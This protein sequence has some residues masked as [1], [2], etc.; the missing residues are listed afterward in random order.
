MMGLI[1]SLEWVVKPQIWKIKLGHGGEAET[2]RKV[3]ACKDQT[4]CCRRK[5][6]WSSV[7]LYTRKAVGVHFAS[8]ACW[9]GV[10]A[11][12]STSS[13]L[14]IL[15]MAENMRSQI[16]SWVSGFRASVS[17]GWAM[18]FSALWDSHLA[19]KLGSMW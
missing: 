19:T 13:D 16:V 9:L 11:A 14:V 5:E 10:G 3:M 18:S 8:K 1:E 17:K 7:R 12:T 2:I 4:P 6:A 15:E